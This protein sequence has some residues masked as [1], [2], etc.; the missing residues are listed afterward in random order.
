MRVRLCTSITMT[1]WILALRLDLAAPME[2]LNC[3][4]A[5]M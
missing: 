3:T 2:S 1:W 4:E 5:K